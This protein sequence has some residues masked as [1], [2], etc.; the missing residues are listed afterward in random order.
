M[1]S[2][3]KKKNSIV[4]LVIVF[5]VLV[6]IAARMFQGYSHDARYETASV[7]TAKTDAYINES[8]AS[9][10]A[11]KVMVDA[12]INMS[13][14]QV[15]TNAFGG[16]TGILPNAYM[17]FC[18]GSDGAGFLYQTQVNLGPSYQSASSNCIQ[19]ME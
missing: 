7:V 2:A 15:M 18:R 3:N 12:K 17:Y 6:A 4:L 5:L 9:G 16:T 13:L 14:K 11:K 10:K 19:V 8:I 1:A